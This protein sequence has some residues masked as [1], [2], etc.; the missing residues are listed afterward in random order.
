MNCPNLKKLNLKFIDEIFNLIT[1]KFYEKETE[2][3]KSGEPKIL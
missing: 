2:I 1:F 3:I